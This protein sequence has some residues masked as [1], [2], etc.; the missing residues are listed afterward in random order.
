MRRRWVLFLWAALLSLPGQI[1][2]QDTLRLT[3]DD[4]IHL[5]LERN[6]S[7]LAVA[8]QTEVARGR[9]REALGA[10]LPQVNLQGA[11]TWLEKVFAVEIPPLFRF[12]GLPAKPIRTELDFT[13]DYQG[14]L[15]FTQP[16]FTS[17]RL[18]HAFQQARLAQQLTLQ[19]VRQARQQTILQTIRSFYGCLLADEF[20]RVAE[21][22]VHVAQ[23]HRETVERQRQVGMATD[24]DVL[25]ARVQEANLMP[26]LAQA[27][28]GQRVA[29]L[30]L[31]TIIGVS[32]ETPVQLLGTFQ[33]RQ[34]ELPLEEAVRQ[35]LRKRPEVR[36][37][38]LQR[39]IGEHALRLVRASDNPT[40]AL[41]GNYN[42]R[43]NVLT[44]KLDRWDDYY[45]VNVALSLPI[46][47]GF[48]THARVTQARAQ[49]TSA[50]LGLE[51][52]RR[53]IRLEVEQA[54]LKFQEAEERLNSQRTNVD[55]ARESVRI[56][57]LSYKQGLITNLDVISA[58]LALM[59]AETNW[60]QALHDCSVADAEIRK[61]V[62][63]LGEENEE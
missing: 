55:Q 11:Y 47:D 52:T 28:N 40:L 44:T 16:I 17:G 21:Q 48:T 29:Y 26:R 33:Y 59:E 62:G 19:Q 15:Q 58:Q 61:A 46:F 10:F 53:A 31:K 2:A 22:A 51:A 32:P 60:S 1:K 3:L 4:C 5:A 9:V 30:A 41:V 35:A 45:T 20:V 27:R 43:S 36:Q 14:T 13:L 38:E 56:A 63:I 18:W 23:E 12:P 34:P 57:E 7:Y 42:F 6:P 37:A 54:Y 39:E 25:R 8:E 24:F 50:D 49:V